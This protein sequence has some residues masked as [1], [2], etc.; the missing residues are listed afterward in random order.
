VERLSRSESANRDATNGKQT[1]WYLRKIPL[2]AGVT[3]GT[4]TELVSSIE[5]RETQ[6]REVVYLPGDPGDRVFFIIGGRVKRAKVAR[7]GKELTLAYLGA[8]DVFGEL[9]VFEGAPREDMAEAMRNTIIAVLPSH[10]LRELLLAHP[11]L[12]FEFAAVLVQKRRAVEGKLAHLIFRDVQ[13]KLASLLLDLGEEYGVAS[14]QG[15]VIGLKITHQ[16]MA[17]LIA[18][19]RETVSLTLAAFRRA[20]ALDFVGRTI[21]IKDPES[22]RR[23]C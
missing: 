18:S 9:C 13:T 23:L 22:L 14:D 12:A 19:T 3:T 21:I 4:L 15:M 5:I 8:G 7:D 16:E 10:V 2:F 20:G 11:G 6:R 17:S 1:L